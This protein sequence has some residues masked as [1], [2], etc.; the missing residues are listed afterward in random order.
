MYGD[1]VQMRA[2]EAE[3]QRAAAEFQAAQ[4]QNTM[5]AN[6][7]AQLYERTGELLSFSAR[8][9]APKPSVESLPC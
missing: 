8:K 4:Q 5:V 6:L 7:Y 2:Y 9:T 3:R 1:Y